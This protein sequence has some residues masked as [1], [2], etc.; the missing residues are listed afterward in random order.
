VASQNIPSMA[1]EKERTTCTIIA[2]EPLQ[3]LRE[4]ETVAVIKRFR[5]LQCDR[6]VGRHCDHVGEH[7]GHVATDHQIRHLLP[8]E[9][10]GVSLRATCIWCWSPLQMASLPG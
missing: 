7:I 2:S 9:P 10:P 5:L 3:T 6:R 4:R 1:C 8:R